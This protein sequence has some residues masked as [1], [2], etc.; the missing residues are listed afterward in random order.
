MFPFSI[1]KNLKLACCISFQKKWLA[2]DLMSCKKNYKVMNNRYIF[3]SFSFYRIFFCAKSQKPKKRWVLFIFWV[4]SH[5]CQKI[6]CWKTSDL[7]PD[8]TW[9]PQITKWWCFKNI[10]PKTF[11]LKLPF[12]CDM[13]WMSHNELCSLKKVDFKIYVM[14]WKYPI[15]M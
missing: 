13:S 6:F 14:N 15:Q 5:I 7:T 8:L 1:V 9:A 4:I 10:C 2:P 3:F 12:N 11:H